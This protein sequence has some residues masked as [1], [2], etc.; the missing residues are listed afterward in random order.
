MVASGNV[1]RT[2]AA[3]ILAGST[4]LGA[5]GGTA[6]AADPCVQLVEDSLA[7]QREFEQQAKD[8]EGKS[9]QELAEIQQHLVD[10]GAELSRRQQASDCSP[11]EIERLMREK[12]ESADSTSR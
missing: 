6:P 8:I 2:A 5:C 3:V 9:E 4:A 10:K 1:R 11:E 7:L 12:D